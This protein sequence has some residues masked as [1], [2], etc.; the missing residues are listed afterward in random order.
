ML[1]RRR[2]HRTRRSGKAWSYRPAERRLHR[3]WLP[4]SLGP[5]TVAITPAVLD[6][7]VVPNGVTVTGS[8]GIAPAALDVTVVPVS[9]AFGGITVA[10]STA[11]I[12]MRAVPPSFVGE[13]GQVALQAHSSLVS[14]FG[15]PEII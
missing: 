13:A 6:L 7:S 15:S 12:D 5:I 10:I 4:P 2:S 14:T 9:V 3:N 11:T 8:A 1:V